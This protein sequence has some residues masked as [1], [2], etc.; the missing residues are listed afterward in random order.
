MKPVDLWS[1]L[2][3][4]LLLCAVLGVGGV[5]AATPERARPATQPSAP[6]PATVRDATGR[7]LAVRP[8]RRI[9][10]TS[11]LADGLLFELAEPERILALSHH[12]RQEDPERQRYG[13]RPEVSGPRELERLLQLKADLLIVSHLGAQAEVAR[14]RAA[15]IAVFDLG[16]LRGLQTLQPNMLA[17]ATL[18]GDRARGERLW[19]RFS[20]RLRAVAPPPLTAA[21][22]A[23]YLATYAGKLYGGTRGT[24]YH[25]V[26]E[27]AG[28]VDLAAL[29][30]RDWPHY[31]PEQLLALNP[32]WIVTET[33]MRAALCDNPWL[34]DLRACADERVQVIELP[35]RVI[36][37]PGLGMLDAA[38]ALHERVLAVQTR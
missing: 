15:G 9:V 18:L 33:G 26:L 3:L 20:R 11:M 37:D 28:L 34:K 17:L 30:Y 21:P 2:W 19:Q 7:E 32:P 23:I 14:V 36:G 4:L 1:A 10:S 13:D 35:A 25:D 24:S 5:F 27:A 31:D 29:Q 8:Y 22:G 6:L 16:E 38:E 12:G